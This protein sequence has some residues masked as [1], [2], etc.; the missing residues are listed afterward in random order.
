M[1][2]LVHRA[3]KTREMAHS[4]SH[5]TGDNNYLVPSAHVRTPKLVKQLGRRACVGWEIAGEQE[6]T[7]RQVGVLYDD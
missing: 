3:I 2:K 4:T 6:K 1:S 7:D 5:I